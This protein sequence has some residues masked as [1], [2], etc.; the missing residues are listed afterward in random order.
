MYED[1]KMQKFNFNGRTHEYTISTH[2]CLE[3]GRLDNSYVPIKTFKTDV[4]K[5]LTQPHVY[6]IEEYNEFHVSDGWKKR[7]SMI[8]DGQKTILARQITPKV[9]IGDQNV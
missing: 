2:F 5:N 9:I 3:V 7:L 6:A 8:N 1:L 4:E